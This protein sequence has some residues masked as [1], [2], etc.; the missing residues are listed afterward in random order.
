MELEEAVQEAN[1]KAEEMEEIYMAVAFMGQAEDEGEKEGKGEDEEENPSG[2]EERPPTTWLPEQVVAMNKKMRSE[3]GATGGGSG[4]DGSWNEDD[5][6]HEDCEE[7]NS[8]D[9][10]GEDKEGE[11]KEGE[12]EEGV[13]E[14][15]EDED[16]ERKI[17]EENEDLFKDMMG[18][19]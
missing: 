9:E 16:R 2:G 12:D 13:D 18:L 8:E 14:E 1:E 17:L 7:E 4:V 10:E 11:D 5:S 15:G 3:V 19:P 6:E